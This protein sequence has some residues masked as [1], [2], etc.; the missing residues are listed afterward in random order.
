MKKFSFLTKTLSGISLLIVPFFMAGCNPTVKKPEVRDTDSVTTETGTPDST[1]YGNCGEGTAMHSLELIT[2]Q[3]DT[4]QYMIAEDESGKQN[5][6]GG[7]LVGDK[8]AVIEGASL[9][10]DKEA[11]KIINMTTLLGKWVSLDKN[12][13]ILDG[14]VVKSNLSAESKPWT[15]WKIFNGHLVLNKDTFDINKLDKDSLYLENQQGIF[16]YKRP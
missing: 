11:K 1:I 16:A 6:Y 12:F 9:D 2:T 5:V 4:I 14:G 13:E 8:L 10:G 3:G 7:L 15:S